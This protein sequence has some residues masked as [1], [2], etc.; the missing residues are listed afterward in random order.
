MPRIRKLIKLYKTGWHVSLC[1]IHL[2]SPCSQFDL[3]LHHQDLSLWGLDTTVDDTEALGPTPHPIALGAQTSLIQQY[4]SPRLVDTHCLAALQGRKEHHQQAEVAC[5]PYLSSCWT[6]K[7]TQVMLPLLCQER[8][9]GGWRQV[10]EG[11]VAQSI[12]QER[13][14]R[15]CS[16][17]V[18]SNA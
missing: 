4:S 6:R 2:P 15:C 14:H 12:A 3:A 9:R 7:T 5:S 8:E 18:N 16:T 11:W 1:F 13:N 17:V 10:Q